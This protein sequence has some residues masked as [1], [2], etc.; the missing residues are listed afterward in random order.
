MKPPT[1]YSTINHLAEKSNHVGLQEEIIRQYLVVREALFERLK[2]DATLTLLKVKSYIM[3]TKDRN[4]WKGDS[5]TDWITVA[6]G[7]DFFTV[8]NLN[9]ISYADI[10]NN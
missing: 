4:L 5:S 7:V 10:Q 9:N 6:T 2:M 1:V 8:G 3:H